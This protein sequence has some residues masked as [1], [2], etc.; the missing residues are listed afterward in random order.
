MCGTRGSLRTM[1]GGLRNLYA[2]QEATVRTVLRI[3]GGLFLEWQ[4]PA[5]FPDDS[6][7]SQCKL[8]AEVEHYVLD[9]SIDEVS[10]ALQ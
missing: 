3:H 1:H 9:T 7:H 2:G 5:A 8:H 6:D 10:F 4:R